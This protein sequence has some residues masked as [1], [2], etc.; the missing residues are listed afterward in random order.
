[1][2][3]HGAVQNWELGVPL[4]VGY[5]RPQV[6]GRV[7]RQEQKILLMCPSTLTLD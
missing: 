6:A 1:M 7:K 4:G 5:S 2:D 3:E